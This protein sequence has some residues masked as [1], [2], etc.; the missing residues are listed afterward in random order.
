MRLLSPLLALALTANAQTDWPSYGHDDLGQRFSPLT[1]INPQNVGRLK[2][3]WQYGVTPPAQ[4]GR[5]A[6]VPTSEVTP[7]VAGGL[8]YYPATDRTLVA[9]DPATGREVWKR[10]LGS[11]APRR[12]VT[13]WAGDT[14]NTAR[15]IVGTGDGHMLALNARTGVPIPG[16]G[17]EGSVS[18]RTGV[19][20]NFPQ[21]AYRMSSPGS[22]YKT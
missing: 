17:V 6:V 12:G 22:I 18:L 2:L 8:I 7:I 19:A 16:F 14:D 1:Q 20:D 5:V 21:M 13:Y 10:D 11:P 15:V 4:P 9:L 3:A